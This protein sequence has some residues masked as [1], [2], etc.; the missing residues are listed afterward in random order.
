MVGHEQEQMRPPQK[1]FLPVTEVSNNDSETAG[2]ASWF[3]PRSTQL[4]VIK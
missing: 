4:M 1:S 2:N 3:R